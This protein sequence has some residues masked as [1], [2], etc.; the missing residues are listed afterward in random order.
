MCC[1]VA[2][3]FTLGPRLAVV[4]WWLLDAV[5][6]EQAWG[7]VKLS[8]SLPAGMPAWLP[9]LIAGFILP[10]TTLAYLVVFP[11]GIVGLDW[12]WLAVG[13]LLDLS[14]HGGGAS[15]SRRRRRAD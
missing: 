6:F 10:W 7:S 11:E 9:T 2:T 12:L 3:L 8:V 15:A 4:V 14:A 13:L 1:V 5:R